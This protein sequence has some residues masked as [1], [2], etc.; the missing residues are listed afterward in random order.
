M[1]KKYNL[2]Y[3]FLS[4]VSRRIHG[5]GANDTRVAN[6]HTPIIS[7]WRCPG[8]PRPAD[9]RPAYGNISSLTAVR[10]ECRH[11]VRKRCEWAASYSCVQK[12]VSVQFTFAAAVGGRTEREAFMSAKKPLFFVT[13][14]C[15]SKRKWRKKQYAFAVGCDE[16]RPY[17]SKKKSYLCKINF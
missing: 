13:F 8:L 3:I 12:R 14:F 7:P 6:I 16:S 4:H 10:R 2:F 11:A 1:Q 5:S 17:R 15:G 9:L